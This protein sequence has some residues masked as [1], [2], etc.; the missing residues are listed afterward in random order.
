MKFV[1]N[2]THTS[3][4][5][6]WPSGLRR[7]VKAV[8][9]IGVGS[10]PTDVTFERWNSIVVRTWRRLV[11]T[12]PKERYGGTRYWLTYSRRLRDIIYPYVGLSCSRGTYPQGRDKDCSVQQ[13]LMA[14]PKSAHHTSSAS[15]L[16]DDGG[17]R[18]TAFDLLL[19]ITL[20]PWLWSISL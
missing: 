13:P 10:N 9:F 8:V 3:K 11:R 19:C 20:A 6:S 18:L 15:Y 16:L 7:D 5:T 14:P 12:H 2:M 1:R 4:R 17:S